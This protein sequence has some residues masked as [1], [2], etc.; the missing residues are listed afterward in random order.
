MPL[1]ISHLDKLQ[2]LQLPLGLRV[3]SEDVAHEAFWARLG[4]SPRTLARRAHEPTCYYATHKTNVLIAVIA[5]K[6]ALFSPTNKYDGIH[7]P[8][9]YAQ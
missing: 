6:Q 7:P 3:V 4:A 2:A 8:R 5:G 9:E 1:L